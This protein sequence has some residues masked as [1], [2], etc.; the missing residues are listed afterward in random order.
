MQW[1]VDWELAVAVVIL[2]T[3]VWSRDGNLGHIEDWY[4]GLDGGYIFRGS[5]LSLLRPAIATPG[6]SAWPSSKLLHAFR[7]DIGCDARVGNFL[8]WM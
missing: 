8:Q 3:G 4:T 5:P 6:A 7:M 1:I 2:S